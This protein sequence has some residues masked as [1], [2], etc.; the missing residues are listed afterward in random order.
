M[1][2]KKYDEVKKIYLCKPKDDNVALSGII[3]KKKQETAAAAGG[4]DV[5][6]RQEELSDQISVRVRLIT[7]ESQMSAVLQVGI[8]DK[9]TSLKDYFSVKGCGALNTIFKG[10]IIKTDETF[11]KRMVK[12]NEKFFLINGSFEAKKWKRFPKFEHSDYFYMSDSYYDAVIFKPKMDIY[13]LGFGFL[14]Q[15]EKKNFKIKFKYNIDGVESQEYEKE[16]T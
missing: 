5:E 1:Q 16:I 4:G 7:E 9:I 13:F 8:H 12:S 14:N 6:L 10:E 15:Y 2:I 3:G 11:F